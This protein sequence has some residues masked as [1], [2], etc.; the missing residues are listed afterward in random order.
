MDLVIGRKANEA[1]IDSLIEDVEGLA[2]DTATLYI[3][4][5]I[6]A[7]ED[8]SVTLP[9]VLVSKNFGFVIFDL[10]SAAGDG[11]SNIDSLKDRHDS[12]VRAVRAKLF[13]FKDLSRGRELGV[14]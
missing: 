3:G 9:A 11:T 4:Y 14:A 8:E 1:A 7:T 6:I 5:P 2:D 13:A 10:E 12:I